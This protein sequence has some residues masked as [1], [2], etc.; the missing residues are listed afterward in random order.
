MFKK[1]IPAIAL[2]AISMSFLGCEKAES[3]N[4]AVVSGIN[5]VNIEKEFFTYLE[6]LSQDQKQR[7]EYLYIIEKLTPILKEEVIKDPMAFSQFFE[8]T[9][10]IVVKK[11]PG[12]SIQVELYCDQKLN[13]KLNEKM[14]QLRK[15]H[16]SDLLKRE[17]LICKQ[18]EEKFFLEKEIAELKE[19]VRKMQ[20]SAPKESK[21]LPPSPLPPWRT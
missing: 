5:K 8:E 11:S 4:G 10:S 2:L 21:K 17:N 14:Q 13:E 1:I 16:S 20:S 7:F 3:S 15:S 19:K 18:E 9:F 12:F 6:N